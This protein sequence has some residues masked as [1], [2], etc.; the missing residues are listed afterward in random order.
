MKGLSLSYLE[1]LITADKELSV[2]NPQP[3]CD[4]VKDGHVWFKNWTA[5]YEPLERLLREDM[6]LPFLYRDMPIPKQLL[7]ELPRWN[8]NDQVDWGD[9][10]VDLLRRLEG[11][12]LVQTV[13]LDQLV[14]LPKRREIF[15][16]ATRVLQK[17]VLE[18]Q[19]YFFRPGSSNWVRMA[20][21]GDFLLSERLSIACGRPSLYEGNFEEA[22]SQTGAYQRLNDIRGVVTELRLPSVQVLND[23]MDLGG[24]AVGDAIGALRT[25]LRSDEGL[26]LQDA[27]N[28]ALSG[29]LQD[30]TTGHQN[31]VHLEK[32]LRHVRGVRKV[33]K[34]AFIVTTVAGVPGIYIPVVGAASLI[35]SVSIPLILSSAE[36]H[37]LRSQNANFPGIKYVCQASEDLH[38]MSKKT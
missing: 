36:N 14:P 29:V 31:L 3:M 9:M 32:T 18:R 4:Q 13:D 35:A 17:I 10:F 25:M 26:E 7:T 5:L 1:N 2:Y 28:R 37:L 12:G 6:W 15:D 21:I 38:K 23:R 16:D 34:I 33:K 24:S 8:D 22:L 30:E 19:D 20:E 11:E 27:A